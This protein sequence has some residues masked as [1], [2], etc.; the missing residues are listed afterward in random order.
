MFAGTAITSAPALPATIVIDYCY[1]GMFRE[2]ESLTQAPAL[3]A[4]NLAEGCYM[5]MFDYCTSLTQAPEL[6][7]S[8]L[9]RYCYAYMFRDCSSLGAVTCLATNPDWEWDADEPD[10]EAP[11]AAAL[12]GWM[13]NVKAT[14]TFTRKAGVDWPRGE[15]GVPNGWTITP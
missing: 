13:D 14:G 8:S 5:N 6:K 7:A 11:N 10:Y 4:T 15:Y 9:V 1:G 12:M 2:C 3:P